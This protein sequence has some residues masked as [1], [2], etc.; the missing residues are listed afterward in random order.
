MSPR[1]LAVLLTLLAEARELTNA[2]L[3]AV[4]GV[5]LDGTPRRRLNKLGLVDSTK[6]GRALVHEL[7]EH[8]AQWCTEELARPRPDKSGS[9]G[10][11]LYAVLA[12]LHRYLE[13]SGQLLTDVFV[14]DVADQILRK[15]TELTKGK[16]DQV[17]LAE[18]R[19]R[20][21]HIP[22]A[23]FADAMVLLADRDGVHVRAEA[24]RKTLTDD[25]HAAA[26]VLGGTARHLLTVEAVR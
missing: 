26:V 13:N 21:P 20:L 11:A 22:P 5:T 15:Y 10:G 7:T 1:E 18:L 2:E 19:N 4:A 16:P 12:G 24:D 17:R 23:D 9:Y 25:D 8:G 6:V 14:P 3:F